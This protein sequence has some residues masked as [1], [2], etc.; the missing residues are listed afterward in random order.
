MACDL[1]A[2]YL[3]ALNCPNLAVMLMVGKHKPDYQSDDDPVEMVDQQYTEHE[4]FR[5][6]NCAPT[7]DNIM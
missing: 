2:D 6:S 5:F 1:I 3:R 4:R 7:V